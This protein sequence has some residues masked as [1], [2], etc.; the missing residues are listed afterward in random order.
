MGK[1]TKKKPAR[2]KYES[3]A[4]G[5]L[6][7][8]VVD[9]QNETLDKRE[10]TLEQLYFMTKN[11][12]QARGILNAIKYPVKMARPAIQPAED[13]EA[14]ADF[15][16]QNL[17]GVPHEGG[18]STP[19]KAVI[20]RMA[21]AVR[22]GYK[23]FEKV[24]KYKNNKIYLD[25]LAYRGTSHTKFLIDDHGNINGAHQ[26]TTFKGNMIDVK[27]PLE[28]IAYY[29]YNP[30][31]NPYA[32]D[33]GF[34]PVFYHYDKKHKLYAIAH[35]AYQLN[36]IPIRKGMHPTNMKG[37]DLKDFRK[38]ISALGTVI[39]ITY[40]EGC[41]VEPFEGKHKL[42]EYL[43]MIQ[44]HDVMMAVSFLAQFMNLGHEGGGGSFA[45][46]QDQSNLFLMS[47]M[48]L[49]DEI[50]EVFNI[51]VIPQLIDW[52]FGTEKYPRLTFTPFSDTIRSAIMD[53]FKSLLAA[54]FPQISPEFAI[55]LEEQISEELGLKIDYKEVK[56]RMEQER[57]ELMKAEEAAGSI[58]GKKVPPEGKEETDEELSAF[59]GY[60]GF[61]RRTTKIRYY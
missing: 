43:P 27:F 18:L 21:L 15:V 20:T 61:P 55:G 11:D 29:I 38:A 59:L 54:R 42:T 9:F 1:E 45:L 41:T 32:G 8:M 33:S 34:Y 3:G 57:Q 31:E 50:A 6:I 19:L 25:K 22:D 36:A 44:H 2:F 58:E 60:P 12:G 10:I 4:I 35:L 24:W 16:R 53:T 17:L 23:I 28:K 47:L 14:E 30:E 39:S 52:N 56:E 26:E 46:S 13:G 51:Q 48:S 40:P 5:D 7:E 37:D 49:L